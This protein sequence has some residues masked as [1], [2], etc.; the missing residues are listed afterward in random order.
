MH[1]D[2][3]GARRGHASVCGGVLLVPGGYALHLVCALRA[4][5]EG[6]VNV[7][8]DVLRVPSVRASRACVRVVEGEVVEDDV[9]V[10][11]ESDRLAGHKSRGHRSRQKVFACGSYLPYGLAAQA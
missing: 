5:F 4:C 10:V 3:E 2:V 1:V 8:R 6:D 11:G 7:R 9:S